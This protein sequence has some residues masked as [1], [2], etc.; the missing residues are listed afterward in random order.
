MVKSKLPPPGDSVAAVVEAVEPHP[1][2]AAIKFLA[3]SKV[4]HS[5]SRCLKM[6]FLV[7]FLTLRLPNFTTI[8]LMSYV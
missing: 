8:I 7:V 3:F 4:V 2:K 6:M 1:E 5:I